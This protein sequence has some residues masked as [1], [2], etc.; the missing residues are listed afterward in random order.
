M[1]AAAACRR[2][3]QTQRIDGPPSV[4]RLKIFPLPSP[5]NVIHRKL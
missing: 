4:Q 1:A 2:L 5:N 3:E